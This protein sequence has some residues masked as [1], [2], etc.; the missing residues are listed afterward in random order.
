MRAEIVCKEADGALYSWTLR[1]K[2]AVYRTVESQWETLTAYGSRDPDSTFLIG[3]DAT[4]YNQAGEMGADAFYRVKGAI[5]I[6][7][8]F[9]QHS[10]EWFGR[11]SPFPV[12]GSLGTAC[13]EM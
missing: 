2:I 9:H 12:G 3:L 5:A 8:P 4:F 10:V 7:R 13:Q 1:D 11:R 6:P